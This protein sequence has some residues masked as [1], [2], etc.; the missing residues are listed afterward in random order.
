MNTKD[1]NRLVSQKGLSFIAFLA[2]QYRCLFRNV[3]EHDKGIDAEIEITES[4]GTIS[5]IIGL[6]VKS[7]SDCIADSQ[8]QVSIHVSEQNLSYW[9]NYGRPVLLMVYTDDLREVY[10]TRVDRTKTQLIKV[11]TNNKFEEG[12]IKEFKQIILDFYKDISR[13]LPVQH[14]DTILGG[15]GETIEDI[16]IPIR[17]KLRSAENYIRDYDF[18]NAIKLYE[19]LLLLYPSP[20]IKLNLTNCLLGINKLD[21]AYE[22]IKELEADTPLSSI[23]LVKA[24]YHAKK[25]DYSQSYS[26]LE[27]ILNTDSNSSEAWNL[28]GLTYLW[29]GK[30]EQA[31]NSFIQAGKFDTNNET[32][33]FN[34]AVCAMES[35]DTKQA[36]FYYDLSIEKKNNFYDGYNNKGSLLQKSFCEEEA[37]NCYNKAISIRPDDYRAWY[38]SAFLLKDLGEND[39]SLKHFKVAQ[40]LHPN[41]SSIELNIGLLYLRLGEHQKAITHLYS[42]IENQ[43]EFYPKLNNQENLIGI[44]DIGYKVMYLIALEITPTGLKVFSTDESH[45]LAIYNSKELRDYVNAIRKQAG[46]E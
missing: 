34:L 38:N 24:T 40:E 39:E 45:H 26:I 3:L 44:V 16:L 37:L 32:I 43:V 42:S 11:D 19:D 13:T 9:K 28:L 36:L 35:G 5:A 31:K 8:D 15:L 17:E 2:S 41:D 29:Q 21:R 20:Y 12:S 30:Y 6:Q 46:C 10:W 18:K 7:R 22:L 33:F 4:S 1:H 25:G 27:K 14:I 23:Q